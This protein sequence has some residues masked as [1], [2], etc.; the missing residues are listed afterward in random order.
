MRSVGFRVEAFTAA[1]TFLVSVNLFSLNCIIADVHMPG[2][3]GLALLRKLRKQDIM[4]PTILTTALPEKKLDEEAA[5]V[6]A[7]CLIR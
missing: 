7:L 3:G 6:G 4:T 2:T 5:L 1:E